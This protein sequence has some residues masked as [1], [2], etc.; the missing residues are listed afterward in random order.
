MKAKS[1]L[2]STFSPS[3]LLLLSS[4]FAATALPHNGQEASHFAGLD[5]ESGNV[6]TTGNGVT[7]FV[8]S[9]ALDH[10]IVT[11]RETREGKILS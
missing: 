4:A 8:T 1:I 11:H 3:S 6:S 2:R 5:V 7:S 9:D 10:V